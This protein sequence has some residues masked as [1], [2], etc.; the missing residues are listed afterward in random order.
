LTRRER[1]RGSVIVRDRSRRAAWLLIVGL[2]IP[3]LVAAALTVSIYGI[4]FGLPLL[5]VVGPPWW[6]SIDVAR[7][8]KS[9]TPG[10]RAHAVLAVVA[11]TAMGIGSAAVGLDD[12]DA[13]VEV[14]LATV[15]LTLLGL[16]WWGALL[17]VRPQ[18]A[19]DQ[20]R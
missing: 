10:N 3:V 13:P 19:A 15:A 12:F 11:L 8:R 7:K 1:G 6:R 17:L 5:L 2:F 14:L 18:T 20:P 16:S 9:F 4:V